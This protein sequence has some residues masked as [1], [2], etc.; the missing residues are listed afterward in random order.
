[1][2]KDELID[3]PRGDGSSY[4]ALRFA[5][6][7]CHLDEAIDVEA[8]GGIEA[9][10]AERDLRLVPLHQDGPGGRLIGGHN[11]AED[12]AHAPAGRGRYGV[13]KGG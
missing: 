6:P 13:T 1:M 3:M 12:A 11:C 2:T 10:R 7:N 5:C 9:A 4:R 8:A